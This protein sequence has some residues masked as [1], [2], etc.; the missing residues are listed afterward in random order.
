MDVS[1]MNERIRVLIYEPKRPPYD[2]WI[3]NRLDT[4][5][6]YVGGGIEMFE[7]VHLDTPAVLVCNRDGK[8]TVP[9]LPANRFLLD[10]DG[11]AYDLIVGTFLIAGKGD[12]E[13]TSLT[14]DQIR[15]FRE[16]ATCGDLPW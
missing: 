9:P 7:P 13:L 6:N 10:K 8:N 11:A 1:G 4:L 2:R 12:E 15:E 14:A 3:D 5:R 16:A